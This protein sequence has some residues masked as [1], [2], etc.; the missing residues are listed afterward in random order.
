MTN[1]NQITGTSQTPPLQHPIAKSVPEQDL[2]APRGGPTVSQASE[3]LSSLSVEQLLA[4][5]VE[6]QSNFKTFFVAV[7]NVPIPGTP[8]RGPDIPI[9][10][11]AALVIRLR[12]QDGNVRGFVAN[13]AGSATNDNAR[14][15]LLEGDSVSF[16]VTN[17]QGVWVDTDTADA[18]FEFIAEQ[19]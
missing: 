1:R 12:T 19:K 11:G 3:A 9:P 4:K 8:V 6:I 10:D 17:M 18:V 16:R 13:T 2:D 5:L 15:N 14:S 7:V